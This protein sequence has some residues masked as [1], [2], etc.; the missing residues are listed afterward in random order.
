MKQDHLIVKKAFTLISTDDMMKTLLLQVGAKFIFGQ[1]HRTLG[2][3]VSIL[4]LEFPV[5]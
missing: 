5:D 4:S 2:I 3:L 1:S